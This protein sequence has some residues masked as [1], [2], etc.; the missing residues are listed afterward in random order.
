MSVGF[1]WLWFIPLGPTR[2]SLGLVCPA[3]Y[4]RKCGRS[5]EELYLEAIRSQ[6]RI[7]LQVA[8]ATRRG[9]IETTKDWSFL[10]D[11]TYG[12]NWF[13]VGESAG[14]ADPILSAGLTLTHTGA[15][16]LAFTILE[17]DRGE[18]DAKWLKDHYNANQRARVH[19][20]IRFADFWYAAN[21]QFKQLQEHCK[22]IAEE[23]GMQIAPHA[24]W[25]WIAWGGF[26]NDIAGQAGIGGLDLA[27]VKQITQRFIDRPI[28]WE[29]SDFNI[30]KLNLVGAKKEE[31]PLYERGRIAKAVCYVKGDRKLV[32]TG[33]FKTVF[34]VLEE[35]SDIETIFKMLQ[36]VIARSLDPV[37]AEVAM[38][39]ALQALEVMVNDGWV[40]GSLDKKGARLQLTTPKEGRQIHKNDD[41]I[42]VRVRARLQ[43]Q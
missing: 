29:V 39:H 11:R 20:H 12:E 33:V 31:V 43:A 23:A 15:R 10:S 13:L 6:P 30:F 2:T 14:F 40:L 32:V 1:G 25:R 37:H 5:P 4:Y 42:Q 7:S 26:A 41:P 8:N 9:K 28:R 34:E 19:Q 16:E 22:E 35:A 38:Q 17:L 18:L 3:E 21:G 27:G 36:M 24:A